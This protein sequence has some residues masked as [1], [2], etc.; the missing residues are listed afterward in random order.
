[1]QTYMKWGLFV[2]LIYYI[3]HYNYKQQA[4]HAEGYEN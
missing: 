4:S 1:M 2:I 3:A